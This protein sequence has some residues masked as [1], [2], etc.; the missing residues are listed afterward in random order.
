MNGKRQQRAQLRPRPGERPLRALHLVKRFTRARRLPAGLAA[1]APRT[2]PK[3]TGVSTLPARGP[4]A[5][6]MGTIVG[7]CWR[8]AKRH[9]QRLWARRRRRPGAAFAAMR[10]FNDPARRCPLER[11]SRDP[12]GRWAHKGHKKARQGTPV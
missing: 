9:T 4:H 1:L 5:K 3:I 12:R 10:E 2:P 6:L 8:W 11:Q 7:A